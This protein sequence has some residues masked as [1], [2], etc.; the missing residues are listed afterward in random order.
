MVAPVKPPDA[1][2]VATEAGYRASYDG[3][4]YGLMLLP[5]AVL[6]TAL[7]GYFVYGIVVDPDP[8]SLGIVALFASV[9]S[10][11]IWLLIYLTNKYSAAVQFSRTEITLATFLGKSSMTW[12]NVDSV[13]FAAG[14]CAP[15][16]HSK[17]GQ[18]M[19][20]P[21]FNGAEVDFEQ[22]LRRYLPGVV[23]SGD[24]PS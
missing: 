16:L 24:P 2:L 14:S 18:T 7:V 10:P 8:P 9:L 22:C 5:A 23:F 17:S 1:S 6:V 19:R 21:S 20:P 4:G 11:I 13:T 15:I 3:T 12:A